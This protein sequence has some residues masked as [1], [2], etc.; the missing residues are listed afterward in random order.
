MTHQNEGFTVDDTSRLARPLPET[1]PA[2]TIWPAA[3][4]MGITLLSF[5]VVTSWIMSIAG[6]LLFVLSVW[7]WVED[8][9]NEQ[10]EPTK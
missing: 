9:R 1:L 7:G 6:F 4:G 5:G 10:L 8:L 2:P 3:M